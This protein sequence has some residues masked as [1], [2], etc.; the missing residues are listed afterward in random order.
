MDNYSSDQERTA[1]FARAL[2]HPARI[3]IVE[4]L[5]QTRACVCGDIVDVLPLAQ[6]SVS[7]HLKTLKSAGLVK[8][9]VEGTSVCY[10]LDERGWQD[11]QRLLG[12][13]ASTAV[14]CCG[15]AR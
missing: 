9:E 12:R 2:G 14:E 3:A 7:Q 6:A 1:A 13:L 5:A 8:G 10:C 11:A 15:S 4:H